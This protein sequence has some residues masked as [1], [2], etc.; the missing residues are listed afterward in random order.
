MSEVILLLVGL[1]VGIGISYWSDK[2]RMNKIHNEG[3]D[4]AVDDILHWGCFFDQ[5]N[6]KHFVNVTMVEVTGGKDAE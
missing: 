4:H 3:Y 6:H 5:N 2:P 1:I